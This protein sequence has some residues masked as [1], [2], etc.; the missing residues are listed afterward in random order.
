MALPSGNG[1]QAPGLHRDC[2][3]RG[4]HLGGGYELY[5]YFGGPPRRPPPPVRGATARSVDSRTPAARHPSPANSR[6]TQGAEAQKLTNAGLDPAAPSTSWPRAK[7]WSTRARAGTSSPPIRAP[8]NIENPADRA[9]R[10]RTS[11]VNTLAARRR[12]PKPL[13]SI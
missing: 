1:K 4:D 10:G 11:R 3:V 13:P 8:V 6:S 5:D 7:T 9:P 2:P 12:P